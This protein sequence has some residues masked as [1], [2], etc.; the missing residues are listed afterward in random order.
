[1]TSTI[2]KIYC[3]NSEIT[4]VYIGSTE[5]FEKRCKSHNSFCNNENAHNYNYKVYKFIRANGGMDNWI[6]EEIIQCEEDTRYDAEVHYFNTHNS[7]LNSYYPRRTRKEYYLD[8][9]EQ[10]K[11]YYLDNKEKITERKNKK[12]QCGCGGRYT[13]NNKSQH[14]KSKLHLRYLETIE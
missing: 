12:F 2:Y 8:N 7:K 1:M 9:I 6:I 5:N 14:F 3:K 4:E 11:E 10:F 13:S